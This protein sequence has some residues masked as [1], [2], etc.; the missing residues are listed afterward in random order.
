MIDVSIYDQHDN[1][2][3]KKRVTFICSILKFV[4]SVY[5]MFTKEKGTYKM[6]HGKGNPRI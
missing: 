1:Y 5:K 6:C 4:L 2:L 3:Y